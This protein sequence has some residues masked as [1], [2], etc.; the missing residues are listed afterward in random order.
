MSGFT[1]LL[2]GLIFAEGP[3]WHGGKLWFSD[4][5]DKKIWTVDLDGNKELVFE[6]DGGYWQVNRPKLVESGHE[7]L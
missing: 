7:Y 5:H 3:R 2:D 1:T 6:H 4:M